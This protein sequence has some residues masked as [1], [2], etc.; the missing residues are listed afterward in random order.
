MARAQ[1]RDRA[2]V[3]L[4]VKSGWAAAVLLGGS[5]ASPRVLDSRR[6]DLSDPTVPDSRQPYHAGFGT[7]RSRGADLTRLVASVKSFGRSS[8]TALLREYE[9]AGRD[10]CGAG[11]IAGSLVD[12][13]AIANDHIRVHAMEGRLFRTI[14]QDAVTR[15]VV[16]CPTWREKE[17]YGLAAKRLKRSEA[18]LRAAVAALGREVSGSWR[19]EQKAAALAAWLV[20][21]GTKQ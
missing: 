13:A 11:I 18:D 3:G 14:V 19:A 16:A 17:V 4:T 12:P 6:I 20:L 7:A 5:P 9:R 10:L 1:S 8:V 15:R 21:A 2:A